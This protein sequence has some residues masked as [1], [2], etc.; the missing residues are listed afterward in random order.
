MKRHAILVT[1][2]TPN[3]YST[4]MI[5]DMISF[6]IDYGLQ[7]AMNS[8]EDGDV[9][10]DQQNRITDQSVAAAMQNIVVVSG[11]KMLNFVHDMVI[12]TIKVELANLIDE[13]SNI[14]DKR[15]RKTKSRRSQS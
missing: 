3:R 12:G 4:K 13:R 15:K 14:S 2:T 10:I 9:A 5:R 6:C 7:D 11:N 8:Y 1:C